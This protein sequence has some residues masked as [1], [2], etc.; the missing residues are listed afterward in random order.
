VDERTDAQVQHCLRDAASKDGI[1]LLTVA[2]R[3][4]T[5]ADYDSIIVMDA[6]SIAE[7]GAPQKLLQKQP[8]NGAFRRLVDQAGVAEARA[9]RQAAARRAAE[10]RWMIEASDALFLITP[11]PMWHA[12]GSVSRTNCA[13]DQ[14]VRDHVHDGGA[15]TCEWPNKQVSKAELEAFHAADQGSLSLLSIV[16]SVIP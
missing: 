15:L 1:A 2:H 4:Q 13:N 8:N 12:R 11:S 10:I 7:V 14:L 6:G 3:L 5:V 9:V 16:P